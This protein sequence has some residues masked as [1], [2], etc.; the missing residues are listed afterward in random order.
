[1]LK[2][3]KVGVHMQTAGDKRQKATFEGK[4]RPRVGFNPGPKAV[5]SIESP[6]IVAEQPENSEFDRNVEL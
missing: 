5:P 2:L 6:Q 3:E 4:K 1:M